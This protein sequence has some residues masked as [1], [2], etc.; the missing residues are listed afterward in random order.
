MF[1]WGLSDCLQRREWDVD[2]GR[3]RSS[4]V[5]SVACVRVAR[6]SDQVLSACQSMSSMH[7]NGLHAGSA[8]AMMSL[9]VHGDA[10]NHVF[11]NV[12]A[13]LTAVVLGQLAS[14]VDFLHCFFDFLKTPQRQ[15]LLLP[16]R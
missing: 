11:K 15:I 14:R 13:S 12:C 10:W 7:R 3:V 5:R 16:G 4:S 2:S 8:R 6:S 1:G 9:T